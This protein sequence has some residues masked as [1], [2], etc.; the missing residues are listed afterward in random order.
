M[1]ALASYVADNWIKPESNRTA[2]LSA[3][4]G[5]PVAETGTT[6][7][8]FAAM[9]NYARQVGGSALRVLT[10][11]QRAKML[12]A[13]A[14]AIMARKEELYELS[15]ET[16]ATR[17]DGWIDIEGGA[18]TLFAYSSKGRRELPNDTIQI[19]RAHV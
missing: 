5:E 10:F 19:G 4:T 13:L 15:Y 1:S 11:H 12:K 17:A 9:L 7:R 18:G 8:D 6:V 2:I 16:G 14:E 3:I